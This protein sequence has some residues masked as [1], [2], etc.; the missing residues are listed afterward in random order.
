MEMQ[1]DSTSP[2]PFEEG[3]SQILVLA[4]ELKQSLETTTVVQWQMELETIVQRLDFLFRMVLDTPGD[5][6]KQD[7]YNHCRQKAKA[8]TQQVLQHVSKLDVEEQ[9]AVA[10]MVELA[11]IIHNSMTTR[12]NTA[13]E[14]ND[15]YSNQVVDLY[16][17]YQRFVLRERSK[18]AIAYLAQ[19][20]QQDEETR[21]NLVDDD[22]DEEA[23]HVARPHSHAITTILGQASALIHPLLLWKAGLSPDVEIYKLCEM[24]IHVLDEQAQTLTKTVSDWFWMDRKVDEWMSQVAAIDG[25]RSRQTAVVD[26]VELDALV[27]EMAFA[28]QLLARYQTLLHGTSST[29]LVEQELLPEWT[30]NYASLERFLARQQWKWALHMACPVSIVSPQFSAFIH[31]VSCH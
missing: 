29:R 13:K 1:Q 19:W 21:D 22:N 25:D 18:P 10:R 8:V 2:S 31:A 6:M 12:N 5:D 27:E 28:S 11:L 15:E 16:T 17:S 3:V 7:L 9:A 23:T 24:T 4:E 14:E 26:L 30:W 20:R